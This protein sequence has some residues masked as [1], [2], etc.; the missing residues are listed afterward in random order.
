MQRKSD[1]RSNAGMAATDFPDDLVQTQRAWNVHVPRACRVPAPQHRG[2]A[3]PPAAS[4]R[5]D[6]V[7]PLPDQCPLGAAR[8][9]NDSWTHYLAART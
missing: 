4:V 6:V 1:T 9:A 2:A 5:A 3:P 7:A 8:H